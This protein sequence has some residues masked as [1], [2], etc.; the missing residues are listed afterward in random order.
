M[1][2]E[3]LQMEARTEACG[4]NPSE[5]GKPVKVVRRFRFTGF[6]AFRWERLQWT[7]YIDRWSRATRGRS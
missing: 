2:M 1:D 4:T 3:S 7:G 6:T 5:A